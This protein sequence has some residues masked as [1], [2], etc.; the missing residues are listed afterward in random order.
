MANTR[1]YSKSSFKRKFKLTDS[2]L[3]H[4][5]L[6]GFVHLV[7]VLDVEMIEVDSTKDYSIRKDHIKKRNR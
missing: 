3:N 1:I 5:I 4:Y 2:Q 6:F 7:D